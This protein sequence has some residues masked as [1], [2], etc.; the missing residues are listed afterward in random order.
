MRMTSGAMYSSVPLNEV[1][2]TIAGGCNCADASEVAPGALKA[3]DGVVLS[4]ASSARPAPA[5]RPQDAS[6]ALCQHR[7]CVG[8]RIEQRLARPK[9][10]TRK[11][12]SRASRTRR[13]FSNLRSRW[14]TPREWQY[15]NAP[16][17]SRAQRAAKDTSP[18]TAVIH[19][20]SGPPKQTSVTTWTC[21]AERTC[22]KLIS[23]LPRE[24]LASRP[25]APPPREGG[26][27]D[28]SLVYTCGIFRRGDSC[29]SR[30]LLNCR[31]AFAASPSCARA[32][33]RWCARAR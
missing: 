21:L 27:V 5:A 1:R 32:R 7:R 20:E 2:R 15:A 31:S 13:M 10:A 16:P 23:I 26:A 22:T 28:G 25:L 3:S 24:E 4:L 9:S 14:H 29:R 19:P 30:S 8:T 33:T 18:S 6:L 17:T 11:G 12:E